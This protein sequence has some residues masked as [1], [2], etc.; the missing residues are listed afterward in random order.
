MVH[1]SPDFKPDRQLYLYALEINVC[2][3][4]RYWAMWGKEESALFLNS[5]LA[6]LRY[7]RVSV[8]I[9]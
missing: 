1:I 9:R 2:E 3:H 4:L 5:S 8:I 7:D 6:L